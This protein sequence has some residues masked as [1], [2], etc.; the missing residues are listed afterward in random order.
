[1]TYRWYRCPDPAAPMIGTRFVSFWRNVE[2]SRRAI[3]VRVCRSCRI[4]ARM[5][6][7]VSAERVGYRSECRCALP[8]PSASTILTTC[9]G[10][11]KEAKGAPSDLPTIVGDRVVC[12]RCGE[13]AAASGDLP[14]DGVATSGSAPLSCKSCGWASRE[15]K[16]RGRVEH[17]W[18]WKPESSEDPP[19]K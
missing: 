16:W 14:W 11:A 18:F 1:M 17:V 19:G 8:V 4:V 9:A 12:P 15:L 10:A 7:A 6:R 5:I 3:P 13:D 2:D